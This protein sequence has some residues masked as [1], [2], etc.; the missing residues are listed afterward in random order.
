MSNVIVDSN[1]GS[2]SSVEPLKVDGG[3]TGA[4][5]VGTERVGIGTTSPN[6]PLEIT[7]NLSDNV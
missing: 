4:L 2:G 1:W 6:Y 7:Q 5:S 3:S